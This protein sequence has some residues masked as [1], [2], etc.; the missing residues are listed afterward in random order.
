MAVS[1]DSLNLKKLKYNCKVETGFHNESKRFSGFINNSDL[2]VFV[3]EDTEAKANESAQIAL[4]VHCAMSSLENIDRALRLP[5]KSK[6][7]TMKPS[8]NLLIPQ[9]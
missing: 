9:L 8:V 7:G 2:C 6:S 4:Y 3:I 1:L 5:L